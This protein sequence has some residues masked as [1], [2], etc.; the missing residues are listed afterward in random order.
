MK[1]NTCPITDLTKPHIHNNLNMEFTFVGKAK[2]NH[3]RLHFSG[4]FD[5]RLISL[6]LVTAGALLFSLFGC[7]KK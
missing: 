7:F 5:V 2:E 3:P 6:L 1:K 4:E